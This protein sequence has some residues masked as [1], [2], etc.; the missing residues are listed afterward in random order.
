MP[1]LTR[2]LA[3]AIF[4]A[5]LVCA[6]LPPLHA[7]LT[8]EQIAA[9]KAATGLLLTPAGSATAFCVSETGIFVT[10]KA[11]LDQTTDETLSLVLDPAG[12]NEK[13]YPVTVLR[14]VKETNLA[15]LKVKL[16][17]KV[18]AL[19]LGEVSGLFETRQLC[20]LGYPFGKAPA[21]NEKTYPSISVEMRR[22]TSLRKK[23]D[24]LDLISFDGNLHPGN[25]GGPVLD[26]DANVVGII[27]SGHGAGDIISDTSKA[28]L[29]EVNGLANGSV[30]SGGTARF[31]TSGINAAIPVSQLKQAIDT[32]VI[33][34]EMPKVKFDKRY[35]PV[36]FTV[37]VDWIRP[38]A[39]EPV[40]Y[41]ELTH[42]AQ[43][44]KIEAKKGGDGKYRARIAPVP[45]KDKA[46]RTQLQVTL[47]FDG[48]RLAGT[49]TDI[50]ITAD[51]K[52]RALREFRT[53][54]R[55]PGSTDFT[56]DGKPIGALSE[57]AGLPLNMGGT[58]LAIEAQK[59][60]RI[61]IQIPPTI[62]GPISCKA[63]VTMSEGSTVSSE[64]REVSITYSE[65]APA[66][67]LKGQ[68][69]LG[70]LREI[71]LPSAISD[72]VVAQNG[73]ALLLHM[74]ESKKLAVFDVVDLKIRGYINLA[75]D[76]VLFAGGSRYILVIHP[77]ANLI[78]RYSVETL[79]KDRTINNS[80]G[81]IAS[82]A[83]GYS[84]PGIALM[85]ASG[86]DSF[87]GRIMAF[88]AEKMTVVSTGNNEVAGRIGDANAVVRASADGRT[89][90]FCRLGT[91]PS[92]FSIVTFRDNAFHLAYEHESPGIRGPRLRVEGLPSRFRSSTSC[93]RV[94]V[95]AV[96]IRS[97]A[98]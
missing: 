66:P 53:F 57:L 59:A 92:G 93:P 76:R 91:S 12:K 49:V 79:Q 21:G 52:P 31:V 90:G 80:F 65:V 73:R 61:D 10:S 81:N 88:D 26:L 32:P 72:A 71:K 37:A 51:G 18:T 67:L 84:S 62:P 74:K 42:E 16:E 15:F 45:D 33:E 55:N 44:R 94:L 2:L 83:M 11:A 40:V 19:R 48:G 7:E 8:G 35:E 69:E 68:S 38:P 36:E 58:V 6:A 9:A 17:G 39:A 5:A 77:T 29:M 24:V 34:V 41:I 75:E 98:R 63:M 87:N 1:K 82:L 96:R 27:A 89:Y 64:P 43:S 47:E 78:Q 46:A 22:I 86:A 3:A 54:Q 13:R 25:S 70:G 28:P 20:A 4:R 23:G 97:S 14:K 85:F 50:D 60:N 56:A 30:V 95:R